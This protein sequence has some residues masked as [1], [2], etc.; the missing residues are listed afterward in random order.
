M[1]PLRFALSRAQRRRT[2]IP[3]AIL[4]VLLCVLPWLADWRLGTFLSA[5]WL[6]ALLCSVPQDLY[7]STELTPHGMCLRTPW[8]RRV[9]PW[10]EV[11]DVTLRESDGKGGP[12]RHVL[13]HR[14]AGRP[15]VL[16]GLRAYRREEV[17][18]QDVQ[19]RFHMIVDYRRRHGPTT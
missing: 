11:T 10:S 14:A 17:E 6:P 3:A 13:A 9:L 15:I 7:G 1:E 12:R 2:E 8:R 16:P 19:T 4:T 5:I 18:W